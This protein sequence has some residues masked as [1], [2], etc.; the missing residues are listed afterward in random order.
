ML[1]RFPGVTVN[2]TRSGVKRVPPSL[3]PSR[4]SVRKVRNRGWCPYTLEPPNPTG[5]GVGEG[6]GPTGTVRVD[7]G[8]GYYLTT[9]VRSSSGPNPLPWR[10]R[11][12]GES[13]RWEPLV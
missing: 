5:V 3:L 4:T 13:S 12:M 1:G 11:G 7:S 9:P 10:V 8:P 2:R 6:G